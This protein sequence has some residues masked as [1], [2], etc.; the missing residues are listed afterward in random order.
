LARCFAADAFQFVWKKAS[1]DLSIGADIASLDR[2][3]ILIAKLM[4]QGTLGSDSHDADV[5][6][7]GVGMTALQYREAKGE[8]TRDLQLDP[9]APKRSRLDKRG[10]NFVLY[11]ARGDGEL[12]L[13]GASIHVPISGTYFV[14]IGVCSH[15]IDVV[16]RAVFSNVGLTT[17]AGQIA[18]TR[19]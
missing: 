2:A 7:H 3:A 14:G 8:M 17:T 11:L 16:E 12:E 19:P 9:P 10:D 1:G 15:D 18:Q 6:L 4:I 13:A 5:A